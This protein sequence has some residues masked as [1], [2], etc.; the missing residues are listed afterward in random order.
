MKKVIAIGMILLIVIT[1]LCSCGTK[2]APTI[3]DAG[4][5]AD[6]LVKRY[7][8]KWA[9]KAVITSEGLVKEEKLYSS[10]YAYSYE[11]EITL[12]K[13]MNLSQ[14]ESMV[15]DFYNKLSNAFYGYDVVKH[16]TVYYK[17]GTAL[18][19]SGDRG[20]VVFYEALIDLGID[21]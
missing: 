6:S 18:L 19:T 15:D 14:M 11:I 20:Y 3:I 17:D 9:T 2:Q 7:E 8:L 5:K 10:D 4:K 16:F 21:Y 13:N 1:A 12:K